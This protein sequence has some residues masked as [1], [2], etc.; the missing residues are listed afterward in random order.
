MMSFLMQRVKEA[1]SQGGFAALA[2]A[3]KIFAPEYAA[4]LDG[5]SMLCGTL[6]VLIPSASAIK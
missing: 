4:I 2:Q 5:I 6:A 1:S 3:L